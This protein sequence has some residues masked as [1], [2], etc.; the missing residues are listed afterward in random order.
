MK[1]IEEK[2][3]EVF[4]KNYPIAGNDGI[5]GPFTVGNVTIMSTLKG[6]ALPAEKQ[7]IIYNICAVSDRSKGG[8]SYSHP[9]LWGQSFQSGELVH[10]IMSSGYLQKLARVRIQPPIR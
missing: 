6:E 8:L 1:N 5:F 10:L 3:R 7:R 4:A 9:A 2:T